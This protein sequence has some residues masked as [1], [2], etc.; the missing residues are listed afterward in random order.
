MEDGM[1]ENGIPDEL[2]EFLSKDTYSLLIKGDSG[3][4]KTTLALTILRALRPL[5][6]VLYISTRRSPLQLMENHPWIEEIFGPAEPPKE[7]DGKESE[8]WENLVDARLDEP[9]VVFE[10][11]TNVLM[12][13]QAPIVVIDAWESMS[14]ALGSEA[15]KTNI[16]VLQIWRE[17]AGAR[18]IFVGEDPTNSA[19]DFMVDG[20][21]FLREKSVDGRRLREMSISKLHGV[22][23]SKPNYFF[24]L[25]GGMFTGIPGY[26]PKDYGF[27]NPLPIRL[28]KPFRR[29]KGRFPTGYDQ[30]D[31]LLDGGYRARS[32]GL[33]ELDKKVDKRVGLVFLSRI[34]QDWLAAGDSVL[35]QRP[36]DLDGHFVAQYA[37][38]FAGEKAM[39]RMEV[40][41]QREILAGGRKPNN[42]NGR[43]K[44]LKSKKK[45]TLAVIEADGGRGSGTYDFHQ[46]L[47]EITE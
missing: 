7:N 9:N 39:G 14:D 6:N 2:S 38:S 43:R 4:G 26:L 44:V 42:S 10:R 23:I 40:V 30:L 22:K 24:T 11:I 15:L 31:A 32:L 29:S 8:G 34:I 47:K 16:R 12:D 37:K 1:A 45:K 18:F 20:A 21:V 28:D 41:N 5:E 3:T 19:I 36:K 46:Q 35:L 17:R 33:L 13:R 25:E 27:R